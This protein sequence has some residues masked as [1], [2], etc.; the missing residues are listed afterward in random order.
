MRSHPRLPIEDVAT[1][2]V[3]EGEGV[4]LNWVVLDIDPVVLS[5]EEAHSHVGRT[6]GLTEQPW[7]REAL[8]DESLLL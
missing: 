8:S 6:A 7:L 3:E 2:E 5:L 1:R 4:L